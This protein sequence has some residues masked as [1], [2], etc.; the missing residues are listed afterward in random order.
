MSKVDK[1]IGRMKQAMGDLT[2]DAEMRQE[3]REQEHR[4]DT[5][6]EAARAQERADEKR[7]EVS[8]L[9]RRTS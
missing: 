4:A 2:D 3:G 8:D 9:E 1:A 7:R 6:E 5:R